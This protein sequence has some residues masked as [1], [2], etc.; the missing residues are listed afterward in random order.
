VEADGTLE[1]VQVVAR[2]KVEHHLVAVAYD[3]GDEM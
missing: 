3:D 2:N 1:W